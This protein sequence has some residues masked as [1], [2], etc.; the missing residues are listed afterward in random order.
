[1]VHIIGGGKMGK[2]LIDN[3]FAKHVYGYTGRK[4]NEVRVMFA[5]EEITSLTNNRSMK[6]GIY[7]VDIIFE[8]SEGDDDLLKNQVLQIE[9]RDKRLVMSFARYQYIIKSIVSYSLFWVGVALSLVIAM[10][11]G[12]GGI[13]LIAV[14]ATLSIV[15][16]HLYRMY[17]IEIFKI[18]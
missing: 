9:D 12:S 17:G 14:C 18:K 2:I 6:R 7:S 3:N 1:M 10:I 4:V 15:N 8:Y 13:I 11:I 5:G 16:S